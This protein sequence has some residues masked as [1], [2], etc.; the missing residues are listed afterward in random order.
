ML[1]AAAV[2]VLSGTATVLRALR[3]R[4]PALRLDLLRGRPFAVASGVSFAYGTAL[5]TTMLLGVLFLTGAWG[6]SALEA[7]LAMSP[8]ALVTAVVGVGVGRLPVALPPRTMVVGGSTL[9]AASTAVLALLIDTE[10]R[11]WTLWL[12]AGAVMG[13]GVGLATVGI[14][15]AA[16]FSVAPR[17]FAAATGMVMAARQVGGGLGIAATA[18]IIAEV[19]GAG[20]EPYA[21]VYWF[22]T[23]VNAAAA[24]GGLALRLTPP[25][26]PRPTPASASTP[27][28]LE[29][30]RR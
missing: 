8:A 20:A 1:T 3:H 16:A 12:P 2:T 9:I 27:H 19:S 23:A 24:A 11:F 6:Y 17:H 22:A 14:S 29:G 13:V 30:D 21:A 26:P 18:V 7:G 28:V 5:F 25:P 4:S 15:S 10:P